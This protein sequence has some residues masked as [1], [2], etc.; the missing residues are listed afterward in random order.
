MSE[1][2]AHL[3]LWYRNFIHAHATTLFLHCR[4]HAIWGLQCIMLPSLH[5]CLL[6]D[7]YQWVKLLQTLCLQ[8]RNLIHARATT[9]FLHCR[10]C[11]IGQQVNEGS[12][13]SR[14]LLP[15]SVCSGMFINEWSCCSVPTV[16]KSHPC[17]CHHSL[18]SLWARYDW[19][20]SKRGL[21]CTAL[22]SSYVRLLW[23]VYQWVKLL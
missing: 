8:Y 17:S 13:A 2:A 22:L 20:T 10:L 6:W 19:S 23:V 15:M 12:C 7:V 3:C 11:A 4:L 18:P 5:V 21:W 14:R 16:L 1:I 9:L